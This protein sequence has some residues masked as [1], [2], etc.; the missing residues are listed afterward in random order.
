[1]DYG[2][3]SIIDEHNLHFRHHHHHQL[4]NI[5]A[6]KE[7]VTYAKNIFLITLTNLVLHCQRC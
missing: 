6:K 4:S 5:P 3:N 1:M 2:K 7:S